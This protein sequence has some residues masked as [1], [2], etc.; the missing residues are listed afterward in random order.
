MQAGHRLPVAVQF[1]EQRGPFAIQARDLRIRRRHQCLGRHGITQE[2]AQ[3]LQIGAGA[4][5]PRPSA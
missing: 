2:L 5:E 4:R 1:V 3:A